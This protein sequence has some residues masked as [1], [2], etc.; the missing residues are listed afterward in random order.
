MKGGKPGFFPS[1]KKG[2]GVHPVPFDLYDPLGFSTNASPEKKAKGLNMEVNNG[3]LAMIGLMGFLAESKVPGSVPFGP[4]LPTYSGEVM[5]P[6]GPSDTSVPYVSEM[7]KFP[8]MVDP[9][10]INP[11]TWFP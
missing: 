3:R 1:L 5:A 7:L 9:K 10:Y 4:P 8:K 6:W 11:T 2:F